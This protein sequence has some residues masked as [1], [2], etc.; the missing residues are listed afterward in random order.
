MV[1]WGA[2]ANN[3]SADGSDDGVTGLEGEEGS[4]FIMDAIE[5]L[6]IGMTAMSLLKELSRKREIS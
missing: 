4:S 6:S 3:I 5:R 2:S 1:L